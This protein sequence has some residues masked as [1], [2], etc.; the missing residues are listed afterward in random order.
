MRREVIRLLLSDRERGQACLIEL[1]SDFLGL[2][3]SAQ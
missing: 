1:C 2:E 3:G